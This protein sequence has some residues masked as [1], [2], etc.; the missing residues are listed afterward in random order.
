MLHLYSTDKIEQKISLLLRELKEEYGASGLKLSTEDAGMSFEQIVYWAQIASPA[1]PV[2]VKIGGPE[3]R[4]DMKRISALKDISGI[5]AP[6]VE[7]SYSLQ[8]Y[9]SSIKEIFERFEE[10]SIHINVETIT[11]FENLSQIFAIPEINFIDEIT[12]GRGDLSKSVSKE[13]DDP[14]VDNM[15]K[16]IVEAAQRK[17]IKVSIGGAVNPKNAERVF[18]QIKPDKINTRSV[19]FNRG[20]SLDIERSIVMALKYEILMMKEDL[21]LGFISKNEAT[22]RIEKL[23]K[24]MTIT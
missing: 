11:A 22:D 12:I 8:K 2:F 16:T 1:L 10:M 20:S 21:R 15:C 24:R 9:I 17:N 7:S 13:V 19:V 23:N 6:M 5:I 18:N 3:A 14:E 4:N